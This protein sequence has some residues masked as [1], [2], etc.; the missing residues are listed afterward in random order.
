MEVLTNIISCHIIKDVVNTC[1]EY[2]SNLDLYLLQVTS[3]LDDEIT[4]EE[5]NGL[6]TLITNKQIMFSDD[7]FIKLLLNRSIINDQLEFICKIHKYICKHLIPNVIIRNKSS[8]MMIGLR[9]NYNT[10]NNI[11]LT[12]D[13]DV[14]NIILSHVQKLRNIMIV[15]T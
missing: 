8:Q 7:M 5:K 15:I 1:I 6:L 2:L 13:E 11:F 10:Y 9:T 12:A 14:L 3:S 4:E